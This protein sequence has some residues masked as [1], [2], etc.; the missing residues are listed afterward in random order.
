MQIIYVFINCS[1][2]NKE[3]IIEMI[4]SILQVKE[5]RG[6]YGVHDIFV[7]IEIKSLENVDI[8]IKNIEKLDGVEHTVTLVQNLKK[9]GKDEDNELNNKID[10]KVLD[11]DNNQNLFNSKTQISCGIWKRPG[12]TYLFIIVLFCFILFQVS[13]ILGQSICIPFL[14]M[15]IAYYLK[16]K[17][18]V[19]I[20]DKK[21]T[22][23]ADEGSPEVYHLITLPYGK[24]KTC[25]CLYNQLIE[26]DTVTLKCHGFGIKGLRYF[27]TELVDTKGKV[28]SYQN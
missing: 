15:L 17:V 6:L 4:S 12:F 10:T 18:T 14:F 23:A 11:K 8:I 3:K 9:E 24:M 27:T 22:Y 5:V 25:E 28:I 1:W 21:I 7:K 19:K 2:A 16:K 26:G 13:W 20:L